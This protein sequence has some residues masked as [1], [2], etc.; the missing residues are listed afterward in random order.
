[1]TQLC[2]ETHSGTRSP[3]LSRNIY[4]MILMVRT[5][6]APT[7]IE[8]HNLLLIG[9]SADKFTANTA[10]RDSVVIFSLWS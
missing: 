9:D 7:S 4:P 1:M 8:A 3:D 6:A 5:Y 10:A 2:G